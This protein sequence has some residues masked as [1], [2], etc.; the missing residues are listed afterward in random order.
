MTVD[1]DA[2]RS[3]LFFVG[4]DLPCAGVNAGFPKHQVSD[5][6]PPIHRVKEF[7]GLDVLPDERTLD[8]GQ[9]DLAVVDR[10]F[11]ERSG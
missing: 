6:I 4:T 5:R 9:A 2:V 11:S 1:N 3:E 10:V 8:I 7:S